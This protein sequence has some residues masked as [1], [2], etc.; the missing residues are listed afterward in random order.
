MDTTTSLMPMQMPECNVRIGNTQHYH[1]DQEKARQFAKRPSEDAVTAMLWIGV[2]VGWVGA[3]WITRRFSV[4]APAPVQP[5]QGQVQPG[6]IVR[7]LR[8]F[9]LLLPY[10]M[11][12]CGVALIAAA[13]SHM[14]GS[15]K[16]LTDPAL[17][18]DCVE[19]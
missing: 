14:V 6:L 7:M 13:L 15:Q 5:R 1:P 12:A 19:N 8:L 9:L 18:R 2:I 3:V 11:V 16:I 4:P 17:S 10:L